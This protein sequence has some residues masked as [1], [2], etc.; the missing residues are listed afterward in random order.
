MGSVCRVAPKLPNEAKPFVRDL[1]V[2]ANP[3][4]CMPPSTLLLA[5]AFLVIPSLASPCA[6]N[7]DCSLNGVC[8]TGQC[9]CDSPWGGQ[10]CE[11]LIYATTPASAKNIWVGANTNASLNSWNGPIVLDPKTMTYHA[12]VPI[13][14]HASLWGTLFTAHGV[15]SSPTGPYD[16]VSMP[17]LPVHDI[18]PGA[19][20]Y[21]NT[22]SSTGST[23]AVLLGGKVMV[24][25]SPAGPFL[26]SP[27]TYPG[28]AGSN[29]APIFKGGA[30]YL[31]NQGT[32]AVW[33]TPSFDKPWTKFA[34]IQ[35][36]SPAFPYTV[37]DPVMWVDPRGNWH[38]INH[39][40]NTGEK[41]NCSTR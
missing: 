31:T 30:L 14:E 22:S 13:Y 36:P 25:E 40:Y 21:P 16:W 5:G 18:N 2:N 39:A 37:E 8:S 19:V 9:V 27:Y 20:T 23:T 17:N 7:V 6:T 28:G 15:S 33:T 35:H 34:T 1:G 10:S 24:A 29:P 4:F 41:T 38:I 26:V 32:D 12:Y 3:T 11:T